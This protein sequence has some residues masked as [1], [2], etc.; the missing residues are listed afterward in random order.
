MVRSQCRRLPFPHPV[1]RPCDLLPSY[2]LSYSPLLT[3]FS[4]VNPAFFAS[5]ID[6][7]FGELKV[8]NTLRT[9]FLHAGQW[10][11]GL[12]SSGRRSVNR[13]PHT[14]QSPSQS[15]YSYKGMIRPPA[16]IAAV[17]KKCKLPAVHL[18]IWPLASDIKS[19]LGL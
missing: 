10:V 5:E 7:A 8:E 14:L 2:C 3:R 15:S 11:K 9:G 12:A 19:D 13:P 16:P 17:S 6:S 1:P 4:T 18:S